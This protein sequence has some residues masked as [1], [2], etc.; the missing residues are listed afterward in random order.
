VKETRKIGR[1]SPK[2]E[3]I[4]KKIET[5]KSAQDKNMSEEYMKSIKEVIALVL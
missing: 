1:I 3:I 2:K 4:F 5:K